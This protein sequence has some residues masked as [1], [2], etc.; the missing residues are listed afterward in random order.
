MSLSQVRQYLRQQ[1]KIADSD[2]REHEVAFSSVDIGQSL[3]EDFYH[4]KFG[5]ISS[6]SNTD[7]WFEDSWP[8]TIEIFKKGYNKTTTAFDESVDL[9]HCI[10]MAIINPKATLTNNIKAVDSL[11]MDIEP[12]GDSNDNTIKVS[13]QFNI[14]LFFCKE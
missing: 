11:G 5:S 4:I 10:R 7:N 6:G 2:L 14:R 8:V 12:L 3:L 13:L 9:A 1:I